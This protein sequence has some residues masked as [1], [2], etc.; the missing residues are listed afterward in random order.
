IDESLDEN[1]LS[2]DKTKEK[3][4]QI[5]ID[6]INLLQTLI[7][8]KTKIPKRLLTPDDSILRQPSNTDSKRNING[9]PE[10]QILYIINQYRKTLDNDSLKKFPRLKIKP[11]SDIIKKSYDI[12]KNKKS[13]LDALYYMWVL[14]KDEKFL[15]ENKYTKKG[16]EETDALTKELINYL[17]DE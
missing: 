1:F 8:P 3:L 7:Q 11:I 5:R 12:S 15:L 13:L 6:K 9:T 17:Y 16:I 14:R 4:N 2:E 10:S